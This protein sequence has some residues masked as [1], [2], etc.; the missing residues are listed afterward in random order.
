[1]VAVALPESGFVVVEET[2]AR[3]PLRALPEVEVGDEKAGG[4]AVFE[5]EGLAV[6]F[7]R[8]PRVPVGHIGQRE[9]RGVAGVTKR[10]HVRG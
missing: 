9:V 2:Q 7:P 8:D 1:V 5:G 10:H 6:D 4:S 3:D